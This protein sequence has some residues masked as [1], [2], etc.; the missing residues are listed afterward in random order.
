MKLQEIFKNTE[1]VNMRED[2]RE[3]LENAGFSRRDMIKGMGALVVGFSSVA[4]VANKLSAEAPLPSPVYD[5]L[6][7]DS[8]I[9]IAGD[10][11]ITA[12]SGKCDMGQGFRTVQYQLVADEL[13]VPIGRVNLIF[14]DTALCPDQGTTSGS[15]SHLTEFGATGL[16]QALA[17]AREAMFVMAAT[18][19][20]TTVDQLT[21]KDGVISMKSNPS[22]SISYGKL[23]GG[24]KFSL[25]TN[26]KAT[27]KDPKDYTVLG[28]SIPRYDIPQKTTGEYQYVQNVRLPGMLHGKVVR[29]PMFDSQLVRINNMAAVQAMAGKPKVVVKKNFIGVVADTEWQAVQAANTLDVTWSTAPALPAQDTYYATMRKMP[30]RDSFTVNTGD[31]DATM[32]GAAKVMKATYLHPYQ[33][34][35]SVGSSCAVADVWIDK[36]VTF[37]KI[38]SPTQG[39][40]PQRDSVAL[41]LGTPKENVRVTYV[42]GSGCY[43]LNGADTVSYDA[44]LMSQAVGAPVRVQY[45][46]ADEMTGGEHFGNP[47]VVDLTAGLDAQSRIVAW[48]YEGWSAT[49]GNRPN[50]TSPGNVITG[51]L[52]GFPLPG[53]VPAAATPP[54]TFGNNSNTAS[55]YGSGCVGTSCGS[56]G[57]I[58]SERILSHSID[59]PFF[60]G[61]LRSPARLQ[62]TFANECFMDELAAASKIDPVDYRLRHLADQRLIDVVNAAAKAASWQAR[63]SPKPGNAKTGVVTGRGFACV[64]YE[65]SN[66][67]SAMVADVSVNQD[68]GAITVTKLTMSEDSGPVSNPDGLRNQMEG[69]ALQGMSRALVEEVKWTDS[70][71]SN[72]DWRRYPVRQFGQPMP[73]LVSVLI[74]RLDKPQL[75]AGECTITLSAAAIGNA[76]F[77]ATGA[78]LRQVPFT[79]AN[80][81]AALKARA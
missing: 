18:Q 54:T 64:L 55:N 3:A 58:R 43:G 7:V 72:I 19:L 2:A 12:Y 29:P 26:A 79:P 5:L 51:F 39:V 69:G 49:R 50:A 74:N 48:D 61:P 71:L 77:D 24:K 10:E 68:T 33:M 37:A 17:T 76:V 21:V 45:T 53:I 22:N 46:R 80:V 81:L 62:N 27:P 65:G 15:Q 52:A 70:G 25:A 36:G 41:V 34:H 9:A 60:T 8:W 59:S 1:A 38:W 57:N 31:V 47:Y 4:A 78:R 20:K 6:Q 44:A 40:Y 30:A 75:G 42:E 63:P 67:Y 14:C 73:E 13:Y 23:I 56:T 28:T 66:G 35:G 11:S 16:R 32:K